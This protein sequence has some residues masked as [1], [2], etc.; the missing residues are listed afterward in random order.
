MLFDCLFFVGYLFLVLFL[1]DFE[2]CKKFVKY[3]DFKIK[4]NE[5]LKFLYCF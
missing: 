5:E 1:D 3:F 4:L 2:E